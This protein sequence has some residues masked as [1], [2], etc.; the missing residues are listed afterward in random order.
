MKALTAAVVQAGSL[1][2]DTP[3][4]IA[5]LGDLTSDAAK[6]GAKV[7]VFP[8][9]FVGGYPKGVDFGA[10]VGSRTPEGRELFHR[11]FDS[12][13][14]VPGPEFTRISEI[15]KKAG[16]DL[17]V[18]VMERD[19]GTLYCSVLCFDAS[20]RFLGKRRK[21]MPNHRRDDLLG[22]LHADAAHE[23]LRAEC[24]ALLRADGR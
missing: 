7:V 5:K 11:Y 2:F 4:T 24:G 19:G 20:G 13:I 16:V 17:V 18:G 6:R 23:F 12:A 10:R 15:A 3:R 9:A 1:L 8:E 21:L 14:D 22:K